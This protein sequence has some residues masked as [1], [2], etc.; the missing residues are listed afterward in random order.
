MKASP[1]VVND[2]RGRRERGFTLI[3]L[4]V[5]IAII[6]ILIGLLVPAVQKVREA[7]A[8]T[9]A[10]NNLRTIRAAELQYFTANQTYA[11]SFEA[12]NLLTQFPGGVK[13][14]YQF[15]IQLAAAAAGG[16]SS[17]SSLEMAA[18]SFV[19]NATP[20]VP[21]V[22]GGSDCQI[23]P[24]NSLR[25]GPNPQADAGRRQ[26]LANINRRAALQIGVLLAQMPDALDRVTKKL[27]NP[28]T[29]GKTFT[30][31]DLDG[32]GSVT[33]TEISRLGGRE[34]LTDLLPYIEQQMQLG[35]GGENV[36]LLPGVSL[37]T[38][39]ALS[40]NHDQVSVDAAVADGISRGPNGQLPAVQLQGFCDG[41]VR[42]ANVVVPTMAARPDGQATL[43]PSVNGDVNL[44]WKKANLFSDLS[45]V[46]DQAGLGWTGPVTIAD[47][48]GNTLDGILIGLLRHGTLTPGYTFQGVM[49]A[50]GG[51]GGMAGGPGAGPVSIT[52]G[53]SLSGPFSGEIH[54]KPFVLG[55]N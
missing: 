27:Q 49:I 53:G 31:V 43:V 36:G 3:E 42:V 28:N 47:P 30:D 14:G 10:G 15:S 22:T 40:P 13:D 6:A 29:L 24:V 5:V 52:F 39:T 18:T 41:S 34:G 21:G 48:D 12:L 32:D 2:L 20:V 35:A 16:P 4:L 38:L 7:A 11:S 45:P 37:A 8:R 23:D 44:S 33:P 25:C 55:S 51:T 9:T 46:G 17:T 50:S 54:V 26:M 19:A 1:F